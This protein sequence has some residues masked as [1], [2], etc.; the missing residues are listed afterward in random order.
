MTSGMRAGAALVLAIGAMLA[1]TLHAAPSKADLDREFDDAYA[2]YHLP[3]LAVG[4]VVDGE[5]VYARTQ[6]ELAVGNGQQ[7]DSASLFKIASN[8]KAMTAAVLARLVDQGKLAWDDPVVKYLPDF[9]MRE[10]WVTREMQVRDLLIHNSGLP[11][12]AGD[13]M[14]WPEPNLFTRADV[15]KAMAH[16]KPSYSFR[17]RYAYS[18]VQ[19]IVAGEVAAAAGGAPYDVLVRQEIFKPLGMHRCQV[20]SWQRDAVGNVVQPHRYMD[21]SNRVVNAD[22][23]TIPDVPMMA[24]GGIRCGLDDM[25][26]WAKAWLQPE[27]DIV[28]ADGKVWLSRAQREEAWK[29]HM[30]MPLTEQMREWDGSHFSGYGHGWRLTDVDGTWKVS[31]T[32][33]LSGMFSS[34]VLL[35]QKNVGIVFMSNGSAGEA[36]TTL[37]QALTKK[38]TAS[39]PQRHSV[40][41]YATLLEQ[42]RAATAAKEEAGA[43]A[44]VSRDPVSPGEMQDVLGRYRD[45][46]FGDVD[47]CPAGD[48]VHFAS[49]KSP[50]LAGVVLRSQE[51]WFVDWHDVGITSEA[52]LEFEASKT[53]QGLRMRRIDPRTG[54]SYGFEGLALERVGD[55]ATR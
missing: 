4:V 55:C 28:G 38:F 7:I 8:S 48:A 50:R 30:P 14:L 15:I 26:T 44:P 35:P 52:W 11:G 2:R 27:G 37:T 46:W 42:A 9:R 6:G 24:A 34:V 36:R 21:G 31:H 49:Q 32:G 5:V 25:L 45:P 17:T 13:L 51:R 18:N 54:S 47:V 23:E 20:G 12:A 16:L 53:G 19:Y 1:M 41:Y 22:G 3:G 39:E 10:D 40:T 33:T 43:Y 29:T